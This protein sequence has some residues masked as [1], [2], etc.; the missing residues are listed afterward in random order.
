MGNQI[1][2][3]DD[4]PIVCRI[5]EV[6]LRRQGYKVQ[7][8]LSG[9]AAIG[10]LS[11]SQSA[12]KE[13]KRQ[14]WRASH[15]PYSPCLGE[16]HVPDLVFVDLVFLKWMAIASFVT[17]VLNP[18]LVRL[19]LSFSQDV[20]SLIDKLKGSLVGASGY[21]VKPFQVD[22]LISIVQSHLGVSAEAGFAP[23]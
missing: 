6:G 21:V 11:S 17:C 18:L 1:L 9:E 14:D 12:N 13:G 4:S 3:I 20:D 16:V 2:I 19:P 22:C 10:M 15:G 23:A 7:C 5:I 8:Y